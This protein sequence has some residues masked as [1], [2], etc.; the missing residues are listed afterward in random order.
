MNDP[1]TV[2]VGGG[3]VGLAC[4]YTLSQAGHEVIVVDRDFNGDKAS[5]GNAGG[6]AVTECMPLSHP[7][8]LRKVPKWLLDPLGPLAI[9]P[10]YALTLIPWL[11]RFYRAGRTPVFYRHA[12]ALAALNK[13]TYHDLRPLLTDIG[14]IGDLVPTGALVLYSNR[15]SFEADRLEWQVKADRAVNFELLTRDEITD[16]EPA[17]GPTKEF[18]VL[19]PEW[20]LIKDPKKL[21]QRLAEWLA[22]QGVRLIEGDVT[23]VLTVDKRMAGLEL[24]NSTTIPASNVVIAV[25][26]WSGAFAEQV[27]DRI[28]LE[29]ERGYNTTLPDPGINIRREL[30]FAEEK[31]VVSPLAPGLR[32]GGAAEFAG[33]NEPPNFGR[34]KAL[35]TLARRHLPGLTAG[36]GAEWMGHRPATPDSLPIIGPSPNAQGLYYACGHGHLG[37]TQAAT[38]GRLIADMILGNSPVLESKPYSAERFSP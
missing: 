30:I 20:S 12:D 15:R 37:L 1:R 17:I 24:A 18:G 11:W 19:E 14:L 27:G 16:L 33:L 13:R 35:L 9:Q 4:A 34:A 31:F 29:S 2:I 10:R 21:V 25:G 38:T 5:F 32:I 6:I 28:Y 26:A 7:G 8:V 22:A 36:S 3:V 23:E